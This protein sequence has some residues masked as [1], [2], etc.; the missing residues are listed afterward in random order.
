MRLRRIVVRE[1][2]PLRFRVRVE[3]EWGDSTRTEEYLL[4]H[5]APALRVDATLDWREKSHLLKLRFAVGLDD[6]AATYET[7]YGT[8]ARPVDG[9][10]EPAP[11]AA[12]S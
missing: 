7:P 1:T 10:E 2:R 4:S 12:D 8:I 11:V 9:A 6:P 5:N 3:R